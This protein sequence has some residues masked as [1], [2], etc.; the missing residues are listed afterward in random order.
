MKPIWEA[1][2]CHIEVTNVC[3]RGCLYCSRYDRHIRND[4]RFFMDLPTIE[5]ALDS[6]REWPNRIGII[7][8]EPTYH[9]EFEAIC[10]M[11]QRYHN[12]FKYGLWTMGG[13]RYQQYRKLI[14]E[15]F[16]FLAYNEH[17]SVQ[18]EICKHQPLTIAI[19][20]AVDNDEYRRKL[21]DDCW[22]QR[23]WCP[24][25]GPKGAF[26]CEVAYALDSILGGPGGYPIKS[27]WWK[28]APAEFRD[29]VDRYCQHCGMA[30]PLEREY[31]KMRQEKFSPGNLALFREHNLL[32]LSGSDVILY[33]QEL[34]IEEMEKTKLTW[35]PGNYRQ[36]LEPDKPEGWKK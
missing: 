28:K 24:S 32:H 2:F 26:F 21:I 15:T 30:I 27:G 35:D 6:L 36:D 4:Q 12:K 33:D 16:E 34:T 9:P 8:G 17:D 23:T 7:G 19:Q 5:K 25:I 31:L 22:V 14:N 11:L 3:G 20:D 1:W 10:R 13:K 29:Q 18:R